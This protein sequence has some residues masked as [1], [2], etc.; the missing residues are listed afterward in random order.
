MPRPIDP[1]SPPP[2]PA[3]RFLAQAML[4]QP[5]LLQLRTRRLVADLVQTCGVGRSTAAR[6][7]ALARRLV[8][9]D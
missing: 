4:N 2:A 7:V 3:V 5:A 1:N 9:H 6:A 8:R